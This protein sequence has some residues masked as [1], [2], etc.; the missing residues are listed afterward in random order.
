MS[1]LGGDSFLGGA[2]EEEVE[3]FVKKYI[4]KR[5]SKEKKENLENVLE[6]Y[7]NVKGINSV[8]PKKERKRRIR[9]G[10]L[11]NWNKFISYIFDDLAEKGYTVGKNAS[12]IF[13][14]A[15]E[16]KLEEPDF[17]T[18]SD[19]ELKDHAEGVADKFIKGG[20]DIDEIRESNKR[21]KKK[22]DIEG[23]ERYDEKKARDLF[24]KLLI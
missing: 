21:I 17:Q 9:G 18:L 16:T 23:G 24:R 15:A 2:S 3:R 8:T 22:I 7:L 4:Q 10:K 14:L 5:I 13:I 11:S 1:F 19:E 20:Y 6:K 12:Y